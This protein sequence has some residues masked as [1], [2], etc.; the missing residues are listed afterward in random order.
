[1]GGEALGPVKTLCPSK[2][3]SQGKEAGVGGW[4]EEQGEGER[5]GS[6][7]RRNQERGITFEM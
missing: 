4:V 2:G 1:M 5:I 6:F 3:E 7:R